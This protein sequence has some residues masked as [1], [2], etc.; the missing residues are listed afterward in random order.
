MGLLDHLRLQ[1]DEAEARL[2]SPELTSE[3]RELDQAYLAE[4][5]R[6]IAGG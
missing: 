5:E 3:M 1:K 2:H 4:L 6:L